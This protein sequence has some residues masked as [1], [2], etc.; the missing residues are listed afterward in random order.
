[1]V[2]WVLIAAIFT[3]L[4]AMDHTYTMQPVFDL[5]RVNGSHHVFSPWT[6]T[7]NATKLH[8]ERKANQTVI[9]AAAARQAEQY[10]EAGRNALLVEQAAKKKTDEE[11]AAKAVRLATKAKTNAANKKAVAARKT[12]RDKEAGRQKLLAEQAAANQTR[13]EQAAETK[14]Q[15]DAKALQ[16]KTDEEAGKQKVLAQQTVQRE[17][18]EKQVAEENA[19]A[20][21]QKAASDAADKA[22]ADQEAK[23]ELLRNEGRQRYLDEQA[24]NTT[25]EEPTVKAE[26]ESGRD[27]IFW[28][29]VFVGLLTVLYIIKYVFTRSKSTNNG[30]SQ[31]T[32]S[33][34]VSPP[35]QSTNNDSST[36]CI[37]HM[38]GDQYGLYDV[39]AST[40]AGLNGFVAIFT[41][42]IVGKLDNLQGTT[43]K[44]S[45]EN[46]Q[47]VNKKPDTGSYP[48]LYMCLNNTM[49]YTTLDHTKQT[50]LT[51]KLMGIAPLKTFMVCIPDETQ[52]GKVLFT[53]RLP[54]QG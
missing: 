41:G 22:K 5:A 40:I 34:P 30:S 54:G 36:K 52:P 31:S 23:Y 42:C 10:M 2:P 49:T 38:K 6:N 45:E 14:R 47:R 27:A 39:P 21:M 15:A 17:A 18:D 12:K 29:V 20:A 37:V 13:V 9:A 1:M 48:F 16:T 32:V 24:A 28:L 4:T 50:A 33:T 53:R 19:K 26:A 35:S 3:G 46:S 51:N 11:Q 44:M 8:E 43:I 25:R 7:P